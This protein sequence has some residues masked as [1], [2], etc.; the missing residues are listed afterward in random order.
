MNSSLRTVRKRLDE[1]CLLHGDLHPSVAERLARVRE[2]P[3]K[4]VANLISVE[5]DEKGVWLVWQYIEGA[6][7]ESYVAAHDAGT[8]ERIARDLRRLVMSLHAHGIVHGGLHAR[9]VIIDPSGTVWLTHISPLLF[10]EV[11]QDEQALDHLMAQLGQTRSSEEK[12]AGFDDSTDL[13]ERLRA[14]LLAGGAI[15][16]AIVIFLAILWYIST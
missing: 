7:L 6:T 10:S 4:N 2:L 13:R 16:A 9:N 1:D 12:A 11:E 8:R 3:V 15:L 14:Y 5:R